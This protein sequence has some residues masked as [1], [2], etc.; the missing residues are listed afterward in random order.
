[1]FEGWFIIAEIE[2]TQVILISNS[3]RGSTRSS[4]LEKRKGKKL[5]IRL[6]TFYDNKSHTP[7]DT[8]FSITVGA[9][10]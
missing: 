3:G 9:L 2:F 4:G 8:R 1:M 7:T 6:P 10:V 5:A